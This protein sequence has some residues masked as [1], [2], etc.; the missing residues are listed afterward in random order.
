M[1]KWLVGIVATIYAE[2][3]MTTQRASITSLRRFARCQWLAGLILCTGLIQPGQAMNLVRTETRTDLAVS[4]F[5]VDGSGVTIAIID[6]GI[7]W[8]HPDFI[9]PDGSTR[10]RAMLD[11]SGQNGCE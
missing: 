9:K 7:D 11:M 1:D 4:T 10:I 6:R 3:A 2:N 5:G 8:Q